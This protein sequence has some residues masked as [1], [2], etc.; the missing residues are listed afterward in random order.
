MLLVLE[1]VSVPCLPSMCL[2]RY[3]YP[4]GHLLGKSCSLV[5]F[6]LCCVLLYFWLFSILVS[7]ARLWF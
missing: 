4:S 7:R 2:V 3:R 6:S 5:M 1:S